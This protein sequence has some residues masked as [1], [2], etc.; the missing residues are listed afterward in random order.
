VG[1]DGSVFN[2]TDDGISW[3]DLSGE[4]PGYPWFS[5][6]SS[7]NG[8]CLAVGPF[9][10]YIFFSTDGG[11]NWF[12]SE[13]S[14]EMPP[15]GWTSLASSSDGSGVLAGNIAYGIF[16]IEDDEDVYPLGPGYPVSA[17]ATSADNSVLAAADLLGGPFGGVDGN[18]WISTD[19]GDTWSP[20]LISTN[21]WYGLTISADGT[22]LAAAAYGDGIY[23]YSSSIGA[24]PTMSLAF[25]RGY[26][27][28]SWPDTTTGNYTLQQSTNLASS[29]W[30]N[31]SWPVSDTGGKYQI[32]VPPA[33]STA[34]YRLQLQ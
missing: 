17:V 11:T 22:K 12:E 20:S 23:I 31:L 8:L 33:G 34:F 4:L 28:I 24:T 32:T 9:E 13:D 6:T 7:T 14:G 27:V 29:N 21:T 18:I 1:Q 15:G 25:S 2:S 26:P 5:V 3:V 30:V 16:G 19:N 10:G